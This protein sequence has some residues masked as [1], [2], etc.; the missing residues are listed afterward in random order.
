MNEDSRNVKGEQTPFSV[1]RRFVKRRA[2]QEQ[3]DMCSA[4]L[5]P[6]HQHLAEPKSRQIV[7][8][9]DACAILFSGQTGTK[10]NYKRVP[11]DVRRLEGFDLSDAQWDSL[12]IPIN[13]AFF[14]Q[15]SP[16]AKTVALYPSP[17][18]PTESLLTLDAWSEIVSDNPALQKLEPDVEALLV[19]RVSAG[20]HQYY[21]A[22]IDECYKLVGLIRARWRGLSG[23]AEVWEEIARFFDDLKRRSIVSREA[24]VA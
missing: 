7:C 14:F 1:L 9:C 17:A 6:E 5:A 20:E 23:G 18:G 24:P 22:P 8:A 4:A 16:D 15:S 12:M 11:R 21:I 19:N 2:P 10:T 13:L 3:C